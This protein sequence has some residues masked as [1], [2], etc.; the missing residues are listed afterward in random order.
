MVLPEQLNHILFGYY[1]CITVFFIGSLLR[2]ERDQ[3]TWRASSSQL[4]RKRQLRWGSI[5]FHGGILFLFFGHLI[6]LLTPHVIYSQFISA[7]SKQ[8]FAIITGGLAGFFCFIGLTMLLHRR[9][10]DARIRVTSTFHDVAVL[11]ILWV[12]LSIGLITLPYSLQHSDGSVMLRLSEWAQKIMTWQPGAAELI[13]GLAWP[14]QVHLVL[15]MTIFLIFPFTR[16]V[17][18]W[19]APVGFLFRRGWQIVRTNQRKPA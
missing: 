6:G 12:Q 2:F 15:G 10:F 14:Y 13:N 1:L 18:V 16:L 19:S 4:L 17:H 3:Y 5:L 7:E 11:V 9:L 8:L